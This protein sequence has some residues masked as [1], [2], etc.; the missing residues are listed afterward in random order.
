MRMP[1]KTVVMLFGS[2]QMIEFT[3]LARPLCSGGTMP[4][5]NESAIGAD[6]FINAARTRQKPAATTGLVTKARLRRNA[7]DVPVAMTI[8]R[9]GPY[10]LAMAALTTA[11]KPIVIFE[12]ARSGPLQV[13]GTPYFR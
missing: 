8:A 9:T 10:R 6:M 3:A 5:R 13:S 11:D 12:R 4:I 7:V 1:P 2:R